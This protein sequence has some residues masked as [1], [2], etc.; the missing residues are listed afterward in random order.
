MYAQAKKSLGSLTLT[1]SMR[2]DKSQ[3][4]DGHVTPRIGGILAINENQN[5]RFSYQTGYQNPSSQDQYIGLDVTQT[6][7]M[8]TSPDNIERFRMDVTGVSSSV[9]GQKFRLTGP[10][11][12]ANSYTATSVLASGGDP[13]KFVKAELGNVQPQYVKSYDFGYRINGKKTAFDINVY[14][15][16]WDNFIAAKNVITPMYM[17]STFGGLAAIGAGDFRVM[18]VD[19]NTDTKV[20]THGVSGSFE[21]SLLKIYDLNVTSSFNKMEFDDPTSDYE[22]GFNTPQTRVRVSLGSDKLADN[23]AFNVSMSY[24]DGYLWQQSG[25]PDGWVPENTIFDASANFAVPAV[26]GNIKI[27]ATNIF[28]EEYLPFIGTGAI[29]QQFYVGFTLNP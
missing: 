7:F 25:F 27:G 18:S 2:Y 23:F 11:V 22:A 26:N 12:I 16:E 14:L 4:F 8:G 19:S 10:H 21:T 20:I 24:N 28:G 17:H 13:S 1:G 3:Y 5:V 9:A 6:I 29:G 15:T